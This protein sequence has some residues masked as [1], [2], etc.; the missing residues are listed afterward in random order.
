[1]ADLESTHP[2]VDSLWKAIHRAPSPSSEGRPSYE[3]GEKLATRAASGKALQWLSKQIPSL[4]GGSADLAPSNKTFISGEPAF[5]KENRSG[6]NLHFGVR[7]HGMAALMNG[8]ALHGGVRP[9][10]GTFLI[11]SDYLRPSLR[12]SALMNL[13]VI[14]VFTHDSIFLGEDGPTHQPIANIASLRAI[15]QVNVY[16]PADAEETTRSWELALERG[17]TSAI[18]LTRQGLPTLDRSPFHGEFENGAYIAHNPDSPKA[19]VFATGSEVSACLEAAKL[20]QAKGHAVRV[21][22]VPSWELFEEQARVYREEIL[23][24][25]FVGPRFAVEAASPFGWERFVG[26]GGHIIAMDRFGASAPAEVL[27]EKFGFSPERLVERIEKE[28]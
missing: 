19:I 28:L 23:A 14:Y 17:E 2:E 7:E 24:P 8:M 10:G 1:T 3:V 13:P 6:R 20:L 9:Y 4:W 5:S 12:L 21:V 25:H 15:P 26:V 27:A 11:F 22:A 18:V 16:R